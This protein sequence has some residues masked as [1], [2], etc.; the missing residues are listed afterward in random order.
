MDN[1]TLARLLDETAALLEIDCRRP[2][3]HPLLPPRRRSRG[4]ADAVQLATLATTRPIP[5]RCSRFPASAKAWRLTSAT[6]P[7]QAPC[8]LRDELLTRYKPSMLELL[9]CPAWGRR[10][11]RCSTPRWAT[12]RTST[13]SKQPPSEATCSLCRAW[14]RSSPTSSSRASKT[15]ARNSRPLPHRRRTRTRRTHLRA[16]SP[17]PRHRDHHP[18]GLAAPWAVSPSATSTCSSPVR[19]A[20]PT[21]SLLRWSMWPRCRLIDKLLAKRP[22]QGQLHPAQQPAGRC[23]PAAARELRR[24]ATV[25]HRLQA[26]QRRR[27]GSAPSSAASPC[28]S[29]PCFAS[30]TTPSS[31]PPPSRKSTTRSTSTTFPPELRENCGELEA[32]AKHTLPQA[33][34]PRRHPR[35]PPHA[36][37]RVRR[38]AVHPRD[39]RSLHRARP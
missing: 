13:S 37:L 35:R 28:P 12:F 20:S 24:R 34:R 19:P 9:R 2:V 22:E 4:A 18:C 32:A 7:T 15:I 39:G 14:D 30:K 17:V 38:L 31:P 26:P 36:H 27:C 6:W 11:S 1:I 8:P 29:T 16:H 25:L 21:W 5:R 3:P 33:H 10:P 23:T